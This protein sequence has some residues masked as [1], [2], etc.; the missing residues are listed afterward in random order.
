MTKESLRPD[1]LE[2]FERLRSSADRFDVSGAA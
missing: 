1:E 2:A